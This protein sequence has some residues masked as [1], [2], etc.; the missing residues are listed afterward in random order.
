MFTLSYLLNNRAFANTI[1]PPISLSLV[2]LV[3]LINFTN[4]ILRSLSDKK[5]VTVLYFDVSQAF[6]RTPPETLLNLLSK[7]GISDYFFSFFKNFLGNRTF[8][9]RVMD[10]LSTT[11]ESNCGVPQG[12][13]FGPQLFIAYFAMLSHTLTNSGLPIQHYLYADDLKI[14]YVHDPDDDCQPLQN[15]VDIVHQWAQDNGLTLAPHKTRIVYFGSNNP[16]C[17]IHLSNGII[18]ETDKIRDLGVTISSDMNFTSQI[19]NVVCRANRKMFSIL[20]FLVTKN[21]TVLTKAFT[22]FVRPLL[23]YATPVYNL[24][25]KRLVNLFEKP[26]RTFSKIVAKRS[27][28]VSLSYLERCNLLHLKTLEHRRTTCDIAYAF[29]IINH[30]CA[31]S[32]KLIHFQ[33]SKSRKGGHFDENK[34]KYEA[35]ELKQQKTLHIAKNLQSTNDAQK[36]SIADLQAEVEKFQ[37]EAEKFARKKE[38]VEKREK[39]VKAAESEMKRLQSEN[40]KLKALKRGMSDATSQKMDT[41]KQNMDELIDQKEALEEEVKLMKANDAKWFYRFG[42]YISIFVIK[43]YI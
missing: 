27:K 37:Q 10:K 34:K 18:E 20:C 42:I 6:D 30:L 23:E 26:Q 25:L 16:K 33:S 12:S 43:L 14:S 28:H 15:A 38:G 3:K 41:L 7:I 19:E 22:V 21:P 2:S 17:L 32:P 5:C 11:K 40:T 13:V 35:L 24:K 9:V 31:A 8:Q 39:T 1:P 4:D 36:K 29:K